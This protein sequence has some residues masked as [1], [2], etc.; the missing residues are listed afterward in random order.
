MAQYD[1]EYF[2]KQF[3]GL[4]LKAMAIIALRAALR[5]FP[6]LAQR[7]HATDAA[8][9]FW[10]PEVRAHHTLVVCRCFQSSAFV[11]S[12][13]KYAAANSLTKEADADAAD[14]AFA[15]AATYGYADATYAYAA[16]HAARAD[17][18]DAAFAA[19]A[20]YGYA[21]ATYAYAAAHAARAA[22]DAAAAAT[23]AAVA[24][25]AATT[26]D[27]IST[28]I[29]RLLRRADASDGHGGT[30]IT[31]PAMTQQSQLT[32]PHA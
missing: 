26:A 15:A 29:D 10:L 3:G 16:A 14:A 30:L 24:A 11:N 21:D 4:P 1:R 18:A 5:V 32:L 12:L 31:D 19:A 9:W 28:D 27:A 8:F 25:R 13:T 17:A 6:V 22:N 20:T 7:R 23:R 2:E